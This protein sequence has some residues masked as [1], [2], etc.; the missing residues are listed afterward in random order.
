MDWLRR[1]WKTQDAAAPVYPAARVAVAVVMTALTMDMLMGAGQ[2]PLLIVVAVAEWLAALV[3]VIMP[4]IGSAAALALWVAA[5]MLPMMDDHARSVIGAWP[6]LA[7][8]LLGM[9]WALLLGMRHWRYALVRSALARAGPP[10]R[11]NRRCAGSISPSW[12]MGMNAS[13]RHLDSAAS[14]S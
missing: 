6:L 4:V 5:P 8:V 9:V 11:R 7:I 13:L 2:T 3:Y 14:C 1:I 12:C 10:R